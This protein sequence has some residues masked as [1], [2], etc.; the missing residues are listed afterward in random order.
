MTHVAIR[1]VWFAAVSLGQGM[2]L[3]ADLVVL[4]LV[5]VVVFLAVRPFR[6][7]GRLAARGPEVAL[8]AIG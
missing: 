5:V 6:S 8:V 7:W 4:L 2:A 1:I 3:V